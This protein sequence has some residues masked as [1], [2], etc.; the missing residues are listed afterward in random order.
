MKF[1]A[2]VCEYALDKEGKRCLGPE[3]QQLSASAVIPEPAGTKEISG[4]CRYIC[5]PT[6]YSSEGGQISRSAMIRKRQ[7]HIKNNIKDR[8]NK[9]AELNKIR[10]PDER[11]KYQIAQCQRAI[12]RDRKTLRNYDD[13]DWVNFRCGSV[14]HIDWS[15]SHK[16]AYKSSTSGIGFKRV[17]MEG[18]SIIGIRL[19]SHGYFE[20]TNPG[21]SGRCFTGVN[22]KGERLS[23]QIPINGGKGSLSIGGKE[24][25]IFSYDQATYDK[26]KELTR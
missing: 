23:A 22:R 25:E 8:Q 6:T 1:T 16:E 11:Y 4:V 17:E 24:Y 15:A 7:A 13:P 14:L 5:V 19:K 3:S 18:G 10:N 12:E 9:L 21:A 26:Y 2:A 20:N